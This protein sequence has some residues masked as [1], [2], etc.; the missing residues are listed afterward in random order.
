MILNCT[1]S[2]QTFSMHSTSNSC[3]KSTLGLD[4]FQNML[5]VDI[6]LTFGRDSIEILEAGPNEVIFA[7]EDGS[8]STIRDVISHRNS[9]IIFILETG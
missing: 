9:L 5:I 3:T 2:S 1:V 4:D 7:V 6:S 8:I